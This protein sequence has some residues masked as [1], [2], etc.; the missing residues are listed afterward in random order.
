MKIF[1]RIEWTECANCG[2]K[3]ICKRYWFSDGEK[4][5]DKPMCKSCHSNMISKM[6]E[7]RALLL[8]ELEK[9][10]KLNANN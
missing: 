8:D 5:W 4:T 1:G 10:G 3:R 9:M 7:L 2:A 6:K